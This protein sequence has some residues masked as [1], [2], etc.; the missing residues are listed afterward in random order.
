MWSAA[1]FA[2]ALPG[3][4]MIAAHSP[5]PSAPWSNQAVRGWYPNPPLNVGAA[6]SLAEWT[7]T[8]VASTSIT[9]GLSALIPAVGEFSPARDHTRRRTSP[10]TRSTAA[11]TA[12]TSPARVLTRRHTVG[13]EATGPKS[14]PWL[15]ST[16]RSD[17]HRPPRAAHSARSTMILPG[18]CTAS[19]L[20]QDSR[21]RESAVSRPTAR[22]VPVS[23]LAPAGPTAGTS[24]ASTPTAGYNPV[25]F[26]TR[27]PLPWTC[28]DIS[29]PHYPRTRSTLTPTPRHP[30]TKNRG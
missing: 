26:T 29:N 1:V 8:R 27:V 22:I 14:S 4:S 21:A 23:S 28:T 19:G 12:S 9:N 24:P 6:P 2:P 15:R 3:R 25:P 30:T 18:S 7:S 20:R 5:A 10:R 17:R 16:A 13:S 11:S